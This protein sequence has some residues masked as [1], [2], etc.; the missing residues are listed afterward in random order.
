MTILPPYRV[1]DELPE[2][3]QERQRPQIKVHYTK[4][5]CL[6]NFAEFLVLFM[7]YFYDSIKFIM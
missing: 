1:D 3:Q 4:F 2:A 7:M 6:D 5:I